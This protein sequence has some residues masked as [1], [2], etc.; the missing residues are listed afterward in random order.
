MEI[1]CKLSQQFLEGAC[2]TTAAQAVSTQLRNQLFKL[3]G[4]L[5]P[6]THCTTKILSANSYNQQRAKNLRLTEF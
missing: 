6:A 1:T 4:H 2:V 5:L 3:S